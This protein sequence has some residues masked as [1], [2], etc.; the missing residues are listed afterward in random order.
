M[1]HTIGLIFPLEAEAR[2]VIEKRQWLEIDIGRIKA[3]TTFHGKKIICIQ[4]GL[5]Q[6]RALEAVDYLIEHKVE[7]IG[8]MGIAAGLDPSLVPG[9]LV[10]ADQV[11]FCENPVSPLQIINIDTELDQR[12]AS[13]LSATHQRALE[14][15]IWSSNFVL[16]SKAE[17][18]DIY[19]GHGPLTADMES[20]AIALRSREVDLPCFILRSVCDPA[21]R[22]VPWQLSTAIKPDGNINWLSLAV[23]L[24]RKPDLLLDMM[25]LARNYRSALTSLNESW[26]AVAH[27]L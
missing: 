7:C 2:T 25:A 10:L 26:V 8:C 15:P 27:C 3:L 5:G 24:I 18:A 9:S 17:K 1:F 22:S 14:G 16:G 11:L 4:S 19:Q 12:L 6:K 13:S 23:H 20:G 21:G